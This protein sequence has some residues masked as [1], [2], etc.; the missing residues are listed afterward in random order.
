MRAGTVS[1]DNLVTRDDVVEG[2]LWWWWPRRGPLSDGE[3]IEAST[4]VADSGAAGP[5]RAVS[6]AAAAASLP[7]LSRDKLLLLSLIHI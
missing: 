3:G 6:A 4:P 2:S 5:A 1:S 7:A